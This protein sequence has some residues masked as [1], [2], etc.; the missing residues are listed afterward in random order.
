MEGLS[1]ANAKIE[2]Q[3]Q[4]AKGFLNLSFG[5]SHY[6][7]LNF[8]GLLLNFGGPLLNFGGPLL[9]FGGLLLNFGTSS[10]TRI[11]IKIIFLL[12]F[13]SLLLKFGTLLLNV[14]GPL[15]KFGGLLL[16]FGWFRSSLRAYSLVCS[17]LSLS[18][19]GA[20]QFS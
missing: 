5:F 11:A 19:P 15:L 20:N 16:N 7:L 17:I 6:A 2:G 14:G 18:R 4:P 3:E 9:N 8:G 10:M 1:Q 13:G 12:N